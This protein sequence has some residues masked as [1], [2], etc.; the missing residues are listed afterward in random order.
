MKKQTTAV[1]SLAL[2]GVALIAAASV[3]AASQG[4]ND[5]RFARFGVPDGARV[6]A[7]QSEADG[8]L[9]TVVYEDEGGERST[10]GGV[11]RQETPNPE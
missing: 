1:L 5:D 2:G 3:P 7:T 6:V 10:I 9:I 11:V 8:T 4:G